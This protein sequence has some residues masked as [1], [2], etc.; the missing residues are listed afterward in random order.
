MANVIDAITAPLKAAGDTAEKILQVKGILEFGDEIREL[1]A[2]V[3]AGL[4]A[5]RLAE[6]EQTTMQQK[7]Q[8]LEREVAD[9]KTNNAQLARYEL[10]R[11][12]PGV[13]VYVLKDTEKGAEPEHYAC[14]N[15]FNNGKIKPLHSKGIHNGLETFYCTGCDTQIKAGHFVPP[16]VIKTRNNWSPF[17][18]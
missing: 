9:L 6:L 5:A 1:H 13:F 12:P 2:N 10:K 8:L 7:I 15:C 3:I 11:L 14:E 4:K 18:G 17:D 16:K